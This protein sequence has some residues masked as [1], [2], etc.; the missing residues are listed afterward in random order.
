MRSPDAW[1]P[2]AEVMRPHGVRGELRLKL[3]N[4]DSDVLLS[5][6]E[7][8]VRL[9]D[10]EEHEVSVDSARRADDA[11]LMKLYSID[12]RDR[13]DELRGALVCVKREAFEE[14]PAGEFYACDVLG[15]QV[16]LPDGEELGT[17]RELLNYPAADVLVVRAKDGGK[18]WEVPLMAA[19][20]ENVD[21]ALG[22]V[23]LVT[24]D[25]LERG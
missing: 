22:V 10:G 11:I 15:A 4:T 13:A 23:K 3:F 12:D 14:L 24:L 9:K 8:L 5:Q 17:V 7:V 1:V 19:Y 20:V 6:D 25:G 18:D 21:V 2:L 16:L